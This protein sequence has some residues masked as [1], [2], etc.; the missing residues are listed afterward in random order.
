MT[1]LWKHQIQSA[2]TEAYHPNENPCEHW[3]GALKAVIIH[4]L[5]GIFVLLSGARVFTQVSDS[6]LSTQLAYV[7]WSSL[8][9]YPRHQHVLIWILVSSMV[10]CT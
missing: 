2:F 6:L 3:G 8:W 10:L 5:A 1:Y 4:C 7:V 9:W